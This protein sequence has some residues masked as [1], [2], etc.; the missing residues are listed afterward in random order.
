MAS[1]LEAPSVNTDCSLLL[2]L[3]DEAA[4][5]PSQ[6]GP[7][8]A[9]LAT[10]R[11]AGAPVRPA[12]VLGSAIREVLSRDDAAVADRERALRTELGAR[13]RDR[14]ELDLQ[15]SPLDGAGLRQEWSCAPDVDTLMQV[16]RQAWQSSPGPAA[17]LVRARLNDPIRG[18]TEQVSLASARVSVT[19]TYSDS[20]AELF[21]SE[22]GDILRRRGAGLPL[23]AFRADRLREVLRLAGHILPGPVLLRWA[24]CEGALSIEAVE[25]ATSAAHDVEHLGAEAAG[26]ELWSSFM[27]REH[28][29]QVLSPL[30][31]DLWRRHLFPV[32]LSSLTGLPERATRERRMLPVD[33]VDGRV[34]W[35]INR[36]RV[37][38][39]GQLLL[40]LAPELDR[41]AGTRLLR[42]LEAEHVEAVPLA[43]LRKLWSVWHGV[44]R[45]GRLSMRVLRGLAV[46]R[47]V[48]ALRA[49]AEA[50]HAAAQ[51]PLTLLSDDELRQRVERTVQQGRA[52]LVPGLAYEIVAALALRLV[53]RLWP[54]HPRVPLDL[55]WSAAEPAPS[56]DVIRRCRELGDL[57]RQRHPDVIG[58]DL[59]QLQAT[60]EGD[61][62]LGPLWHKLLCQHGHRCADEQDLAAARWHED[63]APL[64]RALASRAGQGAVS[65]TPPAAPGEWVAVVRWLGQAASLRDWPGWCVAAVLANLRRLYLELAHRL[66]ARD[67]L[68]HVEEVWLVDHETLIDLLLGRRRDVAPVRVR[69]A[70][71]AR[72]LSWQRQLR[73]PDLVRS[74]GLP[75]LAAAQDSTVLRGLPASAGV[76]EGTLRVIDEP[77]DAE[78]T[79]GEVVVLRAFT[80]GCAPLLTSASALITEAGDR[81]CL[82]AVTARALGMPALVALADATR[83]LDTGRRVRIDGGEGTLTLL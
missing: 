64:L 66:V 52:V 29:P 5:D 11:E 65:W 8:V 50:Q 6:V 77:A 31:F 36:L 45:L 10:L 59:A 37:I 35:N 48:N 4:R 71:A 80:A 55:V 54:H 44:R 72:R 26:L 1:T 42:Q 39:A 16:L 46:E 14:R 63:P 24:V 57:L 40:H 18:G 47:S 23:D 75:G 13:L 20:G 43:G 60:V 30:A 82:G 74:D 73:P 2:T 61:A 33:R 12:L 25:R 67:L 15:V 53:Q 83:I 68:Q 62:Q 49:L 21:Q 19:R 79:A 41:T 34:Y 32:V 22:E 76:V 28:L 9:W 70:R 51:Q 7:Q 69:I 3:D 81:S 58:R 27:L 17:I 38:P 56:V 78:C